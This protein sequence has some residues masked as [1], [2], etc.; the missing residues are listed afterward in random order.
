MDANE[1]NQVLRKHAL[2]ASDKPG[3]EKASLSWA[4]LSRADLRE[5]DLSRANL[6]WANLHGAELDGANLCGADLSWANLSETNLGG[7]DLRGADL[8]GVDLRGVDLNGANLS[9]A[10]LRGAKGAFVTGYFG[11]HHAIAAGGYITIG[12]ERHTYQEWLDNGAWIG[13]DNHYT[14][15]EIKDYMDW[16]RLAIRALKRMER[17]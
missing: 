17:V 10:E 15:D 2:W 6:R 7:A 16:I 13:K 3:G 5:A 1:L 4:D 14:D 9:G 11:Q 12:C 8:R